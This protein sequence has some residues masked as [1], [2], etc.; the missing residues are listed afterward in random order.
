METRSSSTKALGHQIEGT[1]ALIGPPQL[2]EERLI[3][4]NM[5]SEE[6]SVAQVLE[7]LAGRWERLF[8]YNSAVSH[9]LNAL[10]LRIATMRGPN[11]FPQL[12]RVNL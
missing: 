8:Q 4:F 5:I 9:L 11:D 3:H 1:L 7:I 10:W 2:F 6:A 12:Y